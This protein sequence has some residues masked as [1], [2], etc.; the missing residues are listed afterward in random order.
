MNLKKYELM[1][2]LRPNLGEDQV[3]AHIKKIEELIGKH[4]GKFIKEPAIE[5]K[6][7]AYSI[8]KETAGIY[9][10]LTYE[11]KTD[12]NHALNELLKYDN[13]VLRYMSIVIE[14]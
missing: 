9:V 7:L 12:F 4:K 14:D 11:V 5:K 2:I 10:I 13:D 1:L 6:N 3:Q 8:K